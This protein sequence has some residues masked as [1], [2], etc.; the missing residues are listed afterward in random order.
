M[1]APIVSMF[2]RKVRDEVKQEVKQEMQPFVMLP[3]Y[4]YLIGV[5]GGLVV[6]I[7][8]EWSVAVSCV[9][10]VG[11]V[12]ESWL[13]SRKNDTLLSAPEAEVIID[14]SP[15]MENQE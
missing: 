1:E 12:F 9:S 11:L 6:S 13:S 4:V 10:I 7:W 2:K 5:I 3:T 15:D 8:R 14:T